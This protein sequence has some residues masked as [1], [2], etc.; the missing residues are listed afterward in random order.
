MGSFAN[1]VFSVLL[2][3][4]QSAIAWLWGVSTSGSDGG[5]LGW[6]ISHW[7]PLTLLLCLVG[8]AVDFVVYLLR[9]QP[10]RVWG[11]VLSRLWP[12]GFHRGRAQGEVPPVRAYPPRGRVY[13]DASMTTPEAYQPSAYPSAWRAND[14]EED[15]T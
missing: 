2:G 8:M 6:M 9:W 1:T 5:L 15:Q 10:Y 13:T 3:W 7:L 4:L 12:E 14:P 11:R